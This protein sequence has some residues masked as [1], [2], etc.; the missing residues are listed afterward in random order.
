MRKTAS[1]IADEV[2]EKNA[3]RPSTVL[4]ALREAERKGMS[5]ALGERFGWGV[6]GGPLR[7]RGLHGLEAWNEIVSEARR[8]VAERAPLASKLRHQAE[9][10]IWGAVPRGEAQKLQFDSSGSSKI[11]ELLSRG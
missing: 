4:T 10:D 8:R 1:E 9:H 3:L 7:P 6:H 5:K 2:L 11:R